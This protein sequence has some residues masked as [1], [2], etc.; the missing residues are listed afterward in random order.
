MSDFD[1]AYIAKFYVAC[2]REH[3]LRRAYTNDKHMIRAAR[4]FGIEAMGI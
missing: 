3:R 4:A 1:S 2:A